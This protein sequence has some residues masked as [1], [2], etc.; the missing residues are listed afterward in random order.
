M[1]DTAA[2]LVSP[3]W[4]PHGQNW[5]CAMTPHGTAAQVLSLIT[6]AGVGPVL[7]IRLLAAALGDGDR[8]RWPRSGT[9]WSHSG[10]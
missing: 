7:P 4:S 3:R 9:T 6:A 10:H 2:F 5:R 8:S 1:L